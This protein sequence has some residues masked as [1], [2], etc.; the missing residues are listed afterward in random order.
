M[1]KYPVLDLI[2]T[3]VQRRGFHGPRLADAIAIG[4]YAMEEA[5]EAWVAY[6]GPE[7]WEVWATARINRWIDVHLPDYDDLR[8]YG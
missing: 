8:G 4:R 7:H 3:V 6:T 2:V 5:D 1:S